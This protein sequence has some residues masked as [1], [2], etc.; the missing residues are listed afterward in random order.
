[1]ST[2]IGA[3]YP[4]IAPSNT[5]GLSMAAAR[6]IVDRDI[7]AAGERLVDL[8]VNP[9][10]G[11]YFYRVET[12]RSDSRWIHWIDAA[13]GG[14]LNKYDALT[15]G[16]GN[17]PCGFGVAYDDGDSTDVKDLTGL[18]TF[19]GSDYLLQSQ[20]QV[21]SVNGETYRRQ[22]THDQ[23]S[24]P[25]PFLG[26]IAA[27]DD[28]S[29]VLPGDKSP[30]QPALVDGHYYAYVTDE[31]YLSSHSYDWV[32]AGDTD[33]D[34][35]VQ[36][37][38]VHAHFQKEYNNAY[39]NGSYVALGDGDQESFRELTTLDVVGHE[40]THAVTDFTSNLIYQDESG[41]LNEGFSDIMA[42]SMEYYA[43]GAGLEPATTLAPD[44]LVGEDLDLR[45]DTVAGF[46]NMADPEEDGDPDHYSER[47]VGGDDNGGVHT[48][49][50]IPNHAYYLLANGGQ[51]ASCASPN[52]HNSA[53]CSDGDQD[54]NLS[55]TGIGLL[56]AE[57]IFFLAFTGLSESATMCDARAATE[58]QAEALFGTGAQQLQSTTDA[59]V[60]VG[61]TDAVCGTGNMPP[62]ASF[63]YACTDL[64]CDFDGSGSSDPDGTIVSYEWNFGDGTTGSGVTVSHTYAQG[65]DYTVTLT[66][67]D[68][69]DAADTD[70]QVVT[71]GGG[72]GSM[73]VSAIDMWYVKRGPNYHVYT[74]VTIVDEG[75][76]PV[77]DATVYLTTT[78]PDDST[79][80]GSGVTGTDG[81][82]TFRVKSKQTGTYVSE[83]T[84]VTH[85]SLS[86]D[87]A[88]N[89][90]TSESLTVP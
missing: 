63:T 44:W 90:E 50:G 56:D 86:Y 7:G 17:P 46:R 12:R 28:D 83:V 59:W 70:S 51:N 24:S 34:H 45:S 2:I 53:H 4:D 66:V 13:S 3:H 16:C 76:A 36:A 73:H 81:T 40:F 14:I 15:E 80:S 64:T 1:V 19:D 37:M 60:A 23:G 52:D 61:L 71:V 18:T 68:D 33:P 67:T 74:E 47:Q 77:S 42:V 9:T 22:E 79:A 78:L 85:A 35:D 75:G 55:V 20:P 88:A 32:A 8:M 10:S 11:R 25:R 65:G 31:Y 38:V 84:D 69:D 58:V 43:E 48:N 21:S 57:Q 41:A 30:A 29:W 27:D 72:G 89:V 54:D 62:M 39:W 82:V 49:S 5:V 6:G 87:S 26:P